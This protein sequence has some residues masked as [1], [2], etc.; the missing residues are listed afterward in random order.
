[1]LDW[2]TPVLLFVFKDYKKQQW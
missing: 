1:M 2:N